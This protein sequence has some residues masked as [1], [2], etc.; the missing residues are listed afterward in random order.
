MIQRGFLGAALGPQKPESITCSEMQSRPSKADPGFEKGG[1]GV[2]SGV[3][4]QDI[5]DFLKNLGQKGVGVGPPS[6]S[7]P[8][9]FLAH[10]GAN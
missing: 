7:A 8:G 2:A 5:F 3:R 1:G 4:S 9:H 6:G 10:L